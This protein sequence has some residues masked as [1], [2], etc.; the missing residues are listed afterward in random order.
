MCFWNIFWVC[1]GF[2]DIFF[3]NILEL[4]QDI[5]RI[6]FESFWEGNAQDILIF[7]GFYLEWKW[8]EKQLEH[9]EKNIEEF[10]KNG[11]IWENNGRIWENNVKNLRK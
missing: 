1:S 5:L 10:E 11:R 4:A 3:E 2:F 7:F 8:F 6:C 9:F